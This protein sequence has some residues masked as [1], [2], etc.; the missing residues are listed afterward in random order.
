MGASN[1]L[2]AD[3]G[4][5]HRSSPTL[6]IIVAAA[7]VGLDQAL[8]LFVSS[9]LHLFE[10]IVIV[11]GLFNLTYIRN[12]GAAFGLLGNIDPTVAFAVFGGA[13]V[14]AVVALAYLYFATSPRMACTR[15][16]IALVLGGAVGNLID[17]LRFREVIDF[18]DI[19]SG[20]YHWPSFNLADSAITIGVV[21]ILFETLVRRPPAEEG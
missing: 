6:L 21:F 10:F 19:Y 14:V 1:L 2:K 17:R 12:P 11:P 9:R 8:K 20:S 4:A 15:W 5:M 16:G 7:V 3:P 13:T 18:I